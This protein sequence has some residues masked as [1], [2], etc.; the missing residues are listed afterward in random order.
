MDI[1]DLKGKKVAIVGY[2]V[3]HASLVLYLLKNKI[4]N[5][6]IL[7]QNESKKE[8][9]DKDL[10]QYFGKYQTI[11]GKN[12]LNNLSDF[13]IIFRTP[14]IPYLLKQIQTAKKAGTIIYSQTKLFFDLCPAKI[15]A[16]TG[17]KGKGTTS[18]L[19]YNILKD[20]LSVKVYLAGNF[21]KDPFDFIDEIR[22]ED[23]VILELS[24]FQLQDLEKSSHIAVI[25]PITP[26]H[27]DRH[28]SIK[29]YWQ[30]KLNLIRFQTKRDFAII[31]RDSNL[32]KKI[33]WLTKAQKIFYSSKDN[34][35]S[36][37]PKQF[38]GLHNKQNINGA[39]NVARILH[40]AD[41][42][43]IASLMK[44]KPLEHRLEFVVEK[45][46]KKYYNDSYSTG[47]DSTIAGINC[48]NKKIILICGGV[49]KG[50]DYIKLVKKIGKKIDTAIIYGQNK[51]LIVGLMKKY[52][53]KTNLIICENLAEAVKCANDINLNDGLVLF[54]PASASFDQFKN[55]SERGETF[56]QL[57]KNVKT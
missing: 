39:I 49:D 48:F 54:S 37:Y 56:K 24:S 15:I 20:N 6:T 52:A 22:H 8:L 53:K 29:E 17:T 34:L 10:K 7:D 33:K 43:I 46:G 55:A 32:S 47:P 13:K 28:K 40:V 1:R 5:L 18:H 26:D 51:N 21:G 42:K 36:G 41:A 30:A 27:Q 4:E 38:I 3:N 44:I 19:I 35:I 45:N 9:I 50:F 57:V 25:T 11:L 23:I 16:V 31:C 14:G 2:G 12:Y